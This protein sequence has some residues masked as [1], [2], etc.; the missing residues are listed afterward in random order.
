MGRDNSVWVPGYRFNERCSRL[1]RLSL[2]TDR[3]GDPLNFLPSLNHGFSFRGSTAG[4]W[5]WGL[6]LKEYQVLYLHHFTCDSVFEVCC[7]IMLSVSEII[8]SVIDEWI[9][10]DTDR[11]KAKYLEED[12]FQCCFVHHNLISIALGLTPVFGGWRSATNRLCH[13]TAMCSCRDA[14]LSL[15]K[16]AHFF[17]LCWSELWWQYRR[18]FFSLFVVES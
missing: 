17:L 11:S 16:I 18:G 15:G 5:R 2:R 8:T 1:F 12:R 4:M 13:V 9:W 14:L 7:L 3:L 6:A 10:N